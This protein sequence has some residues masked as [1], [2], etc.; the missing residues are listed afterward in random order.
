MRC[1]ASN[2]RW[3]L[4]GLAFDLLRRVRA[5]NDMAK[6]DLEPNELLMIEGYIVKL[7]MYDT[8]ELGE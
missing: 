7:M 5:A 2:L 1:D 4:F 6:R 3:C 8:P